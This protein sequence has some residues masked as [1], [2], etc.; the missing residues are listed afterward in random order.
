MQEERQEIYVY[1]KCISI[2]CRRDKRSMLLKCV[3]II[4][5]RRDKRSVLQVCKYYMQEER[6][7]KCVA[8]V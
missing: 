2:I 4:C 1:C 6:Q 7:G 3:S 5:R 8:S